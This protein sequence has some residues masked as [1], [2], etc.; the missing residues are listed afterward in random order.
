MS[1]K[2][3]DIPLLGV[4]SQ[5]CALIVD[6]A[7]SES[8]IEHGEV[9]SNNSKVKIDTSDREALKKAVGKI[10]DIGYGVGTISQT[11]KVTGMTCASCS[12]AVEK[13]LNRQAGVV[14]ATVNLATETA[15]V[16]YLPNSTEF[17]SLKTAVDNA[18]YGLIESEKNNEKDSLNLDSIKEKRLESL[19]KRVI[20]SIGLAIPVAIIGMF[21]P[22]IPYA[23]IIMLVLTAP[24]VIWFGRSFFINAWKQ[25]R[26]GSA[27]MDTLVAVSTGVAF[28]Y[29]LF[30]TIYPEYWTSRGLEAHV[31]YEAAA[32]I[33]AFILLGKLLEENAKSKTSGAIKKLMGMQPKT[34]TLLKN[35]TETQIE[36][37]K[38]T[39]GDILLARPGE[40]IAVDGEVVG[41]NSYVDESMLSGEPVP[42]EKSIGEKV[43]AGT[44][45]QKGSFR[46]TALKVGGDTFLAQI[47]EMVQNAQGSKAPVQKTVDKIA[48]IFVPIV[49]A[50][51]IIT[52]LVWLS[53]GGE[54]AFT[55]AL[56][57]FVTVLVIACPCA[58]GLA[59]P[60]AI[61]VGVGRAAQQG[62]LIKNA[63]SLEKATKIDALVLDKTG[64]ITEGKPTVVHEKWLEDNNELKSI[65]LAM[66]KRSEHPLA[67]AIVEHLSKY[68]AAQITEFDSI[69]GQGVKSVYNSQEYLVGNR[70]LLESR[71]IVI[72]QELASAAEE[73]ENKANTVVFFASKNQL[74][75]IIGISDKVKGSSKEAILTLKEQGIDIYM[76]TG[77]NKK[78]AHAIAN[79]LSIENVEAEMQPDGK[80]AFVKSLQTKYHTVAMVG[81]GI[82]DSAALAEADVSIA[83]GK[84]SDIAMDVA[85]MT[86][87]SSDL[88]KL[89]DA[90]KLSRET[91]KTIRQNLFWAFIYNIIGIPI[92]A[93]LLYPINGFLLSPMIASAAMA[94]SSVSVVTNSLRLRYK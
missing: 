32:V 87:M 55:L 67:S 52:F 40:R 85:Q 2:S 5:H 33:I 29:S 26:H 10:R 41:G 34:V 11:Y 45:N 28:L 81:D 64:T 8:G 90:I 56:L 15:Q 69:T 80:A 66:E 57:S 73:W 12:A 86:I 84:G 49:I 4:D 65:L 94:M 54:D 58:L 37:E 13:I 92:A 78:T 83:M 91:V 60:T 36:I 43:Y 75:A 79:T 44:I 50:I 7:L 46:Y 16:E 72:T 31:Y 68:E 93:G 88:L 20:W 74:L 18:G 1:N 9:D 22:E 27:N 39:L 82:N 17:K 89:V 38:V 47:I 23:E 63:E 24:V 48:S 70:K 62:I 61:M 59:T 53:V 51:A 3:I 6:K 71:N 76:L 42:V 21:F 35:G 14:S 77:D 30:N 25:A 19:K